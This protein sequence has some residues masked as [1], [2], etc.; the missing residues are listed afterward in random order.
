[1][2]STLVWGTCDIQ[3][4]CLLY[5]LVMCHRQ[6]AEGILNIAMHRCLPTVYPRTSL[7]VQEPPERLR[8]SYI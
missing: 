6:V 5:L 4:C 8:A 7:C 1:M 2:L 3:L